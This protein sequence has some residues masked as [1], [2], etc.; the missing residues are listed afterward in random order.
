MADEVLPKRRKTNHKTATTEDAAHLEPDRDEVF[1]VERIV[2]EKKRK[3]RTMYLI[4]WENYDDA[5][6]T[7]EP[8]EHLPGAVRRLHRSVRQRES[9]DEQV[10]ARSERSEGSRQEGRG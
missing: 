1:I 2:A 8:I 4:K 9:R 10:G 3:G 7:W 6:N 5:D